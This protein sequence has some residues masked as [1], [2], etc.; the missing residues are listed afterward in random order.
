MPWKFYTSD[1]A[2][3]VTDTVAALDSIGDVVITTV[4]DN[5]VLAYDTGGN[6]IN[7]TAARV[8]PPTITITARTA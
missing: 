8:W 6:W 5:E 2:E 7:Q 1:G 4:A 3:V